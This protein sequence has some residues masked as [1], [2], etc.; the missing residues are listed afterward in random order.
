MNFDKKKK[1]PRHFTNI[2]NDMKSQIISVSHIATMNIILKCNII[3]DKVIKLD[4]DP[5]RDD[6]ASPETCH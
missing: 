6:D 4:V 3:K 1:T 2:T 5:G